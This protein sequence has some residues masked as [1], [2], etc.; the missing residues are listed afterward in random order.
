MA[1]FISHR[2]SSCR[3]CDRILVLRDGRIV[4]DGSHEA[5]AGEEG[6]LYREMWEAQRQYYR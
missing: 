5:L 6:G 4:Q 3:F 1:M 2:L